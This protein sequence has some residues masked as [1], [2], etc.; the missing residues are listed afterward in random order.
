[1]AAP[2]GRIDAY[3]LL[4]NCVQV[5]FYNR[6]LYISYASITGRPKEPQT[7]PAKKKTAEE[8]KTYPLSF[9]LRKSLAMEFKIHATAN[10]LKHADLFEE[11]WKAYKG[12]RS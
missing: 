8:P 5:F 7:M 6:L 9:R 1:M 11:M 12:K 3:T 2:A 4:R 10:E